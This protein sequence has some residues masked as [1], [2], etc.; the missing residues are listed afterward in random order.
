MFNDPQLGYQ[1]PTVS[2]FTELSLHF[3]I[4]SP[5]FDLDSK[6]MGV[7]FLYPLN[8][9]CIYGMNENEGMNE[10]L[11]EQGLN[12]QPLHHVNLA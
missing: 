2:V 10:T 8:L 1:H 12:L 6:H 11:E 5:A 7:L 3:M 9:S 4:L